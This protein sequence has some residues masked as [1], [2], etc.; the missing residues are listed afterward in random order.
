MKLT[1]IEKGRR[2]HELH[3]RS[4]VFL[5][6]NPWDAGS[7][8]LLAGLGFEALATSS[9]AS[10]GVYGLRDGQI[11]R[12]V[13]LANCRFIA[14]A[15]DIPVSADLENGFG[16]SPAE[17]AETIRLAAAAGLAGCSIEDSTGKSDQPLYDISFATERIAAAVAAA[18]SLPFCFTLTARAEN[19]V[20]GKLDLDDT[21]AR[22]LAYEKAGADVLFAPAL[23]DLAAVKQVCAAVSKPVNFMVGIR[24]KSFSVPELVAAGVKRISFASSLYRAALTSLIEAVTEAK[25][26]GTVKYLDKTITTAEMVKFFPE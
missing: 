17:V 21:I 20:R 5:I 9:G 12:D 8:R 2:F 4:G 18:K 22:L 25:E 16:D 19:F 23:P 7:A 15:V 11:T 6:P 26:H 3:Q 24:G 14:E 1:Q 10:A 13:A